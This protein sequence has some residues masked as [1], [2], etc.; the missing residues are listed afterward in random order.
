MG[1]DNQLDL[2]SDIDSIKSYIQQ[3]LRAGLQADEIATHL[4]QAGWPEQSIKHAFQLAQAQV[5]P[6]P[7]SVPPVLTTDSPEMPP[8]V[9]EQGM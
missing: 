2:S 9:S 8:A 4:R 6:P 5:V 3:Q 1:T 7:I